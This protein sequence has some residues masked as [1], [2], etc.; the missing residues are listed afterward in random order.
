MTGIRK[1][2][3]FIVITLLGAIGCGNAPKGESIDAK[4]SSRPAFDLQPKSNP[5]TKASRPEIEPCQFSEVSQHSNLTFHYD[6]GADERA[7][8][9]QS[10]GGGA[11][12]LDYDRDGIW[13]LYLVQ[14]G[15]PTA[16]SDERIPDSLQQNLAGVFREVANHAH[17]SSRGYGYGVAI[18]DYD[19]DGFDDVYVTNVGG[20][21]LLRNLGDGTFEDVTEA[22]GV[23]DKRWSSSA[24]WGDI[25]LDGD[26]DLFV[27]N[28]LD[29]DPHDPLACPDKNGKPSVCH[30]ENLEGVP[31]ECFENLGNGSFRRVAQEW[32]LQ[33]PQSKS[34]GVVIADLSGNG[35]PDIFVANDTTANFLFV[36][37]SRGVFREVAGPS[38][39]ATNGQGD[40]QA[41]MGI[42][43]GDYNRD[44]F[45]DLYVTHFTDDS[46]TLYTNLGEN[47]FHDN[48]RLCG[49]H[50]PTLEYLGFGTVMADFNQ[51]GHADIYVANGHID[52]WQDRGVM[53]EMPPQLFS[54]DG[55][56]WIDLGDRAGAAFKQRT[57]ARAVASC[58]F[59]DDG[60]LDLA[61]VNQN[62]PTWL[63]RNDSKRGHWLKVELIGRSSNRRGIG[64]RITVRQGGQAVLVHELVGGS[65][66]CASH[67]PAAIFG[68][69]HQDADCS[70]EVRWPDGRVQRLD[71]VTV[72]QNLLLQ[73][74][75]RSSQ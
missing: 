67:Q 39:C 46:N 50:K 26:L 17:I 64:A 11:G 55:A 14:G 30:P 1:H 6:N 36:N 40:F 9:V 62:A 7:L 47:G 68:F 22:A 29:Y 4:S 73:E 65:S 66:Y 44:G 63:L 10:A 72:D 31:N 58:D 52:N 24:T 3:L 19:D 34:L 57:I 71:D 45:L 21:F 38:G 60:D 33:G 27:C 56:Q 43:V 8:M 25:D 54:Y 59:D 16:N 69:G 42:A 5:V 51:D 18:G 41:S 37:E 20:N 53:F 74:H 12:W 61:V 28:Y 32:G 13:D 15:N 49:L 23:D 48:T 75:A 70:V 35:R 2:R